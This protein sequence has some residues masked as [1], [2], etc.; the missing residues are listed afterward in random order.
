MTEVVMEI[1]VKSHVARRPGRT[2]NTSPEKHRKIAENVICITKRSDIPS[3][4]ITAE[5]KESQHG[6]ECHEN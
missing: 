3:D 4:N 5:S 1:Q 6:E 2:N